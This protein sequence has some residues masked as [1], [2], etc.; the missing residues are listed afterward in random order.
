MKKG[1]FA[2]L[3]P[4]PKFFGRQFFDTGSE[5]GVGRAN[6]SAGS[7]HFVISGAQRIRAPSGSVARLIV[8]H[9]LTNS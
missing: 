3:L 6:G 4:A 1:L 7:E 9:H 8:S 2:G 5:F